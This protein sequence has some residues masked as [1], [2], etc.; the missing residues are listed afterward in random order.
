MSKQWEDRFWSKIE[1][2]DECWLWVAGMRPNGYGQFSV[3][4]KKFYPHRLAYELANGPIQEGHVIDHRC[5]V[6][7]CVNPEHLRSISQKQN[8]ENRSSAAFVGKSGATGV[9]WHER[10]GK[11]VVQVKHNYKS[12]HGGLFVS[13]EDAAEAAKELRIKLFTHNDIDRRAA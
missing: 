2:T 11:W 1:K 8:A 5:H 10:A 12:H 9:Y 3:G 13:R 6:K 4:Y 7:A